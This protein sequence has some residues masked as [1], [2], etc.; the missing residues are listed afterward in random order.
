MYM[1]LVKLLIWIA[2][3]IMC[4][5]LK[6]LSGDQ[7][8]S[9]ELDRSAGWIIGCEGKPPSVYVWLSSVSPKQHKCV[10]LRDQPEARGQRNQ[11]LWIFLF[12]INKLSCGITS[13]YLSVWGARSS[14]FACFKLVDN[15]L[16]LK[17]VFSRSSWHELFIWSLKKKNHAK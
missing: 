8:F 5:W 15:R 12:T 4:H 7:C 11:A 2:A 14:S 13:T 10:K 17:F 9:V 3:V 6:T 1:E 16:S